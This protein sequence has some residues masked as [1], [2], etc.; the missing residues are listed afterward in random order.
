MTQIWPGF[1]VA[2]VPTVLSVICK[3]DGVVM[4]FPAVWAAAMVGTHGNDI[5]TIV[6]AAAAID[7]PARWRCRIPEYF[8]FRM[9][10]CLAQR[11][12]RFHPFGARNDAGLEISGPAI[13]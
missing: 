11:H 7:I 6:I 2:P 13:P 5:A 12:R 4:V 8:P 9:A 3:P 10:R 1:G